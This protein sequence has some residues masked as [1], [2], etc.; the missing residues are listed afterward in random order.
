MQRIIKWRKHLFRQNKSTYKNIEKE[1]R[2]REENI[3]VNLDYFYG[4]EG[5]QY[6]FYQIP[7][8]LLEDDE[9]KKIS[10]TAKILYGILLSRLAM[11]KKN[12][13]IEEDTN[14]VYIL[15]NRNDIAKLM[16]RGTSTISCAMNQLI[17]VGL[18]KK[19][20]QGLGKSDILYVM[21]FS[22]A[23]KKVI[24]EK[25]KDNEKEEVEANQKSQVP[26][27]EQE[28]NIEKETVPDDNVLQSSSIKDVY[29]GIVRKQVDYN[30]LQ[31]IPY[32]DVS[33]I[34]SL[35]DIMVDVYTSQKEA[36][37]ISGE[38]LPLNEVINRLKRINFEHIEYIMDCIKQNKTLIRRP[39]S[40]MLAAL[41]KAP[42][43]IDFYYATKVQHDLYGSQMDN[44]EDNDSGG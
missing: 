12:N 42:L 44:N 5:E 24:R 6:R 25:I 19:K 1:E 38:S 40:Y 20:K 7:A 32:Y 18:V 4:S 26:V 16:G 21:N 36:I 14:R 37:S 35:V 28:Q 27:Y 30:T 34:D 3:M 11:S 23:E 39:Y 10:D 15:Y 2:L 13:W 22:S 29:R 9:Y 8:V 33:I 31:Q 41:Y 43:T 17:N